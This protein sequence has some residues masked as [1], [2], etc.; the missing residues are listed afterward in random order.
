[1]IGH[2]KSN[3][4][5][6][7][8]MAQQ[9]SLSEAFRMAENIEANGFEF[10][11]LNAKASRDKSVKALFSSLAEKEKVHQEI[12]AGFRQEFCGEK[13]VHFVDQDDQAAAYIKTVADN[14]VF[15]LNKDVS[16]LVA[17]VQTT[18]SAIRMAIGFEKDTIVFFTAIRG[19]VRDKNRDK[20]DLLIREEYEHIRLLQ[21]EL[22]KLEK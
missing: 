9:F 18:A 17:S 5:K 7:V 22:D 8:R 3:I 2:D 20:V 1:M 13:D 16:S 15:N 4:E 10:Y 11:S 21:E 12:F 14:H 19:A 6:A